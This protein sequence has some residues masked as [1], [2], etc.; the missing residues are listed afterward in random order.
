MFAGRVNLGKYSA[1]DIVVF[2]LKGTTI[3]GR[4]DAGTDLLMLCLDQRRCCVCRPSDH[5]SRFV[6]TLGLGEVEAE[7]MSKWLQ[8][9]F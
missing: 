1:Y 5:P 3:P 6:E 4:W 9:T 2:P 8:S 7:E